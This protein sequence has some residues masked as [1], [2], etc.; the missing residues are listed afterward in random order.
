MMGITFVPFRKQFDAKGKLV[1]RPN[2]PPV[3]MGDCT[4][5]STS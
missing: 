4:D 1:D 2:V 5:M 3:S